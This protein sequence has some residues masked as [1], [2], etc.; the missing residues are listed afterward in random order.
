MASLRQSPNSPYWIACFSLPDG[1]R[2]QRTTGIRIDGAKPADDVALVPA[3][4]AKPG[5]DDTT[6][7]REARRQAKREA[8]RI[9]NQYEDA[10]R[11]ARAGKFS[12]TKARKVIADI[13][14]IAN[15]DNLP[16]SGIKDYM[17]SWLTRKEL[18]TGERTIERYREVVRRLLL[19]L[20]ERSARDLTQLTAKELAGFRDYLAKNLSASTVNVSVK[21]IRVALGQAKRDG[22]V[23]DNAAEQVSIIKRAP[24][25][26]RRPF[27]LDELK[28]IL[29]VANTEWKGIITFGLYTGARLGD[30]VK[31]GWNNI[32]LQRQEIRFVTTKTGR[33]QILPMA[34]PLLRLVESLPAGDT[35]DA[36]LFPDSFEVLQRCGRVGPLS[37]AFYDL[38]VSAGLADQRGHKSMGK[39]RDTKRQVGNLSFHCL[40][41][42]ATSLLKN[43]GVSDAVTMDIIG[44]ESAAISANYTHIEQSTKRE[45]L[46]RMPDVTDERK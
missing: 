6:D 21:I 18:E 40:R 13:Y 22:L 2:T 26:Q 39:G 3:L 46:D 10:A 11:E 29:D 17:D 19:Y 38:M 8:Q 33:S 45:A 31:L 30:I 27:T 5:S 41:H 1:R 14:A 24:R 36:P 9:A 12:D 7:R 23:I 32:D 35:P 37:N 15:Q 16:S 44:H 34:K 42:T 28:R 43:A 25:S 4:Q 20:G